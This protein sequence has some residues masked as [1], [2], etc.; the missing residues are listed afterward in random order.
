MFSLRT[1]LAHI[2]VRRSHAETSQ[3]CM[4]AE[5][6]VHEY[7]CHPYHIMDYFKRVCWNHSSRN[8]LLKEAKFKQR[9][10]MWRN[11]C[12]NREASASWST[13]ATVG[14][15]FSVLNHSPEVLSTQMYGMSQQS[16]HEWVSTDRKKEEEKWEEKL[17]ILLPLACNFHP[18]S[19]PLKEPSKTHQLHLSRL[20]EPQRITSRLCTV[21]LELERKDGN[22]NSALLLRATAF[23]FYCC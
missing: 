8:L 19:T 21:L 3:A 16:L 9:R 2:R 20:N 11:G 4:S 18:L 1:L 22:D 13:R 12:N 15:G 23:S 17:L 6:S 10:K 5:V 7:V 14:S